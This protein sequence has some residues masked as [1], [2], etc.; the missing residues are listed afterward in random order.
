VKVAVPPI[1]LGKKNG[2]RAIYD[3][4]SSLKITNANS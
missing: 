4:F 1:N 2:I 3:F